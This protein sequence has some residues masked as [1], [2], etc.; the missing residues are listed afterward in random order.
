[1]MNYFTDENEIIEKS[2]NFIKNRDETC[3]IVSS[4]NEY[5]PIF[6]FLACNERGLKTTA[7][8]SL[9]CLVMMDDTK[10]AS[11]FITRDYHYTSIS[12][13]FFMYSCFFR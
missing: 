6:G 9:G 8:R 3:R 1:M 7:L 12:S 2:V 13:F 11:S 5:V 4:T 10:S